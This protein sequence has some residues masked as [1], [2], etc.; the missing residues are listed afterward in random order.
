MVIKRL[1]FMEPHR[2]SMEVGEEVVDKPRKYVT[3]DIRISIFGTPNLLC[4]KYVVGGDRTPLSPR[5]ITEYPNLLNP[6]YNFSSY[7]SA[8]GPG[9]YR[10]GKLWESEIDAFGLIF[11]TRTRFKMGQISYIRA[12]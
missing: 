7:L 6:A 8:K 5:L 2:G 3:G 1:C 9:V 12:T 11:Q 10:I 4:T